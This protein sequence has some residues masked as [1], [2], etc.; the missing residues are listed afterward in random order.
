M[1][2][3]LPAFF[4]LVL[5]STSFA[6]V[7]SGERSIKNIPSAEESLLRAVSPKFYKTLRI[8]PV[9][10]WIVVR[11]QLAGTRLMSTRIIHSEMGGAYDPLALELA[12]NL[13]IV[14]NSNVET[15]STVRNVLVHLLLYE[16]ADGRLAV[17]FAN[18]EDAGGSQWRYYGGAWMGV[19]K[20]DGSW[21]T[22]EP[23]RLAPHEQRGPRMYTVQ[24]EAPAP[25]RVPLPRAVGN[26]GLLNTP[27]NSAK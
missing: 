6:A 22:I 14:G 5:T 17:S 16:I 8:S 4:A 7:Y 11:G 10:G 18:F 23:L 15:A 9:K 24:V 27:Q 13:Q 21:V 26:K 2:R 1:R 12:N 3:F 19:H 25:A 20:D